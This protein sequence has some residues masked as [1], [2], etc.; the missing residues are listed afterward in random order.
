MSISE[1]WDS[2]STKKEVSVMKK[3]FS[4]LA[5]TIVAAVVIA[6]AIYVGSLAYNWHAWCPNNEM[7]FCLVVFLYI[8]AGMSLVG[9][10][11]LTSP[12]FWRALMAAT[13]DEIVGNREATTIERKN[14]KR[15]RK[16][17]VW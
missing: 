1:A 4:S 6:C 9:G 17:F 13:I 7:G 2:A 15:L 16:W 10:V 14:I 12:I 3:V 5:R 8:G 11:Y